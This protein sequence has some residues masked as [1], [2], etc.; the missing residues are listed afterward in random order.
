VTVLRFTGE[1]SG[2]VELDLDWDGDDLVVWIKME[3]G[4]VGSEA[5]FGIGGFDIVGANVTARANFSLSEEQACELRDA[6]TALLEPPP[7]V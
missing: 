1:H 3:C 7:R 5:S 6:L 2:P 4:D